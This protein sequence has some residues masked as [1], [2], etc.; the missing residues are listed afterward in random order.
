M[1]DKYIVMAISAEASINN[2]SDYHST[3]R[4]A[5]APGEEAVATAEAAVRE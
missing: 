1:A 5:V 2:G 3:A 4:G